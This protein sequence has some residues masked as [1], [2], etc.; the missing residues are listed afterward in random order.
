MMPKKGDDLAQ[1]TADDALEHLGLS[2]IYSENNYNTE[3]KIRFQSGVQLIGEY[4]QVSD[5]IT[6]IKADVSISCSIGGEFYLKNGD[7]YLI[8]S[9]L[10]DDN[11]YPLINYS[12]VKQ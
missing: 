5:P 12:V 9:I 3:V 10:P 7:C 4:G 2:A 1:I 6:V 11:D 8:D